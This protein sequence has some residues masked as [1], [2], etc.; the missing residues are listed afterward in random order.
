M[1]LTRFRV[2]V[3]L[4]Q[5]FLKYSQES[6][7][8]FSHLSKFEAAGGVAVIPLCPV[9]MEGHEATAVSSSESCMPSKAMS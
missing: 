6:R 2:L 4:S 9:G 5:H 7:V 1:V 3:A 8:V